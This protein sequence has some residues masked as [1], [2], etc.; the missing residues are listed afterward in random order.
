MLPTTESS[1]VAPSFVAESSS[2]LVVYPVDAPPGNTTLTLATAPRMAVC[3]PQFN[4]ELHRILEQGLPADYRLPVPVPV[5]VPSPNE[6]P[7]QPE[8]QE[9][10]QVVQQQLAQEQTVQQEQVAEQ[11]QQGRQ[12]QE[13]A[14]QQHK[15][16]QRVEQRVAEKQQQ[17]PQVESSAGPSKQLSGLDQLREQAEVGEEEKD[18]DAQQYVALSRTLSDDPRI[19]RPGCSLIV[20]VDV[21][22]AIQ[23]G[24]HFFE[25]SD[26]LLLCRG[27]ADGSLR[28]RFCSFVMELRGGLA[29]EL[30]SI[31]LIE[32]LCHGR[33]SSV[34]LTRLSGSINGVLTLASKGIDAVSRREVTSLVQVGDCDT[35]SREA[36]AL[37]NTSE[38]MGCEHIQVLEGP[39]FADS[40][41]A[42]IAGS[43]S[44]A[45]CGALLLGMAS[46]CWTALEFASLT[47]ITTLKQTIQEGIATEESW[48]DVELSLVCGLWRSNQPLYR[49]ALRTAARAQSAAVERGGLLHSEL[50]K[51]AEGLVELFVPACPVEGYTTP[52]VLSELFQRLAQA[53]HLDMDANRKGDFAQSF[54]R[55]ADPDVWSDM[56][57]FTALIDLLENLAPGDAGVAAQKFSWLAAWHPITVQQHGDLNLDNIVMD[58]LGSAW[59]T[60]LR[61]SCRTHPWSDAVSLISAVLFEIYPIPV[62]MMELRRASVDQVQ[63]LLNLSD[64]ALPRFMQLLATCDSRDKLSHKIQE[65]DGELMQALAQISDEQTAR[66][67]HAQALKLFDQLLENVGGR[68]PQ[69]WHIASRKLPAWSTTRSQQHVHQLITLTIE[70]A[71]EMAVQCSRQADAQS[72][73]EQP[74]E[75]AD[76]HLLHLLF[77]LLHSTL[78]AL[79]SNPA[80]LERPAP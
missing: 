6:L 61:N 29:L 50:Q 74:F 54:A 69:L 24:V 43:D 70:A 32:R 55:Q 71:L 18:S 51:L 23:E 41:G 10:P 45:S 19:A 4:G 58:T 22:K 79:R 52:P 1:A 78:R 48:S 17:A 44:S 21:R 57:A 53:G 33:Y 62:G 27:D 77:P 34:V 67:A 7:E 14:Q 38:L 75:P 5:P 46:P 3:A 47:N 31:Q 13:G 49:L 80:I 8:K 73:D 37:P 36:L 15:E 9:Q 16:S 26:G 40:A 42:P 65:E 68:P 72:D 64:A 2:S 12:L 56:S 30:K 60:G 63:R 35:I 11:Q 66:F 20:W 39:L 76:L 59:V 25:S 28:S